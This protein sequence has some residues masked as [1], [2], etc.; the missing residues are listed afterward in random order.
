MTK[1]GKDKLI[2]V[3]VLRGAH[4]V[5]GEVRVKSYTADPE[6]LFTY[7]PLL[8]EAGAVLLTPKSARP[9][10]DHF[11]VRTKENLQK[12]EWDAQRGKLVY[13]PRARLPAAEEDEFYIEDLAGL[14]VYSGGESPA[15]RVR[16]VQNFGSGDL[17]EV[18]IQGAVATVFVPF[19]LADVPVVDIA[20][21]RV[22][23]P[24]LAMW[25]DPGNETPSGDTDE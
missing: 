10:K 5:R 4:G 2:A 16:S 11:I 8:D 24:E 6:A 25:S 3:G 15:G 1:T 9:G 22:V 12:E 23:I 19:T 18:E 7:G 20:A 14:D 13:V 21:R 17:L